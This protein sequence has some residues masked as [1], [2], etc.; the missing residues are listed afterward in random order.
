MDAGAYLYIL[1]C[2]DG[3]YYVGHHTKR[4]STNG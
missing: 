4:A 2:A 1:C 3:R